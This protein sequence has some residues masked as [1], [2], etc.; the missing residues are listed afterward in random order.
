MPFFRLFVL[1]KIPCQDCEA[2]YIGETGRSVQKRITEHK[3]AVRMNNRK[4]SIAVHAWDN[5]H[6]PNWEA[7]EIVEREPHHLKSRVLQAI[8]IQNDTPELQPRLQTDA[9][10]GLD[11]AYSLRSNF[12]IF[13][14]NYR[15]WSLHKI[16][17]PPAHY[18]FS[19]KVH[20]VY[21]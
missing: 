16:T 7:A 13:I 12:S 17:S 4:N 18:L 14:S 8:W 9:E 20:I 21:C 1:Y 2:A 15:I 5:N 10:Q 3:Y 6:R 11:P 19:C